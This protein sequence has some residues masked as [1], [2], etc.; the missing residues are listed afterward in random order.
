ME[1]AVADDDRCSSDLHRLDTVS[2]AVGAR[3][4][5]AGTADLGPL[6]NLDLLAEGDDA[7]ARLQPD[8]PALRRLGPLTVNCFAGSGR[9]WKTRMFAPALGIQEDPASGSPAGPLAC[10]LARHGII[11]FGEEIEI[12]QGTEI[13]RPSVLFAR[14]HG[15]RDHIQAVE[16]AG[17]AVI[18]GNGEFHL[19]PPGS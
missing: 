8:F 14:A 9:R 7:V 19:D 4:Q 12:S 17:A 1:L 15:S 6:R 2:R 13:G 11:P 16:V 10:H 18:I 5:H 3:E